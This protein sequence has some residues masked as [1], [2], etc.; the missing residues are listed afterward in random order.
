M[1]VRADR[2]DRELRF[3]I[4]ERLNDVVD[5]PVAAG[6]NEHGDAVA[7]SLPDRLRDVYVTSEMNDLQSGI[8]RGGFECLLFRR[9]KANSR[10]GV[11]EDRSFGVWQF[12]LREGRSNATSKVL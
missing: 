9:G 5:R 4:H 8:F 2:D 12:Q 7:H 10:G 1:V 6:G 11:E 3:G